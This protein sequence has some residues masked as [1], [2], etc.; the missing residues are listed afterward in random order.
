MVLFIIGLLGLFVGLIMLLVNLIRKKPVKAAKITLLASL[1]MVVIGFII[2]PSHTPTT[3]KTADTTTQEAAQVEQ[4][5]QEVAK[6]AEVE[7]ETPK[8]TATE[9]AEEIP[10]TTEEISEEPAQEITIGM[11]NALNKALSYL[12]ISH[13][14]YDELIEQLEYNKF[15]HEE[16]VYAADNCGA[17]W[18]EQA[19]LKAADYLSH[20]SFSRQELIDQLKYNKFTQEQAEYGVSQNGY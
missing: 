18:N 13:F 9:T 17:D 19:A 4:A 20:F 16:A 2:I 1:L 3:Q 11:K 15:T 10:A 12:R 8:E 5:E 6:V 14:S 7:E